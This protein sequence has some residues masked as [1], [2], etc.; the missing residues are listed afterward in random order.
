LHESGLKSLFLTPRSVAFIGVPR[1]SGP[2]WLNPV[3]NL[4]SWGYEGAIHLVHPH[5]REIAGLRTVERISQVKT[6]VDL[7]VVST[8]RETIPGIM[9][10]CA[11]KAIRAVVVTNQGFGEADQRG[12]ELERDMIRAARSGGIRILGPNTLGVSNAFD[13]F[14][15]SF[16]PLHREEV[17]VGLICQSGV[18]F[19]G[20]SH[21]VGGMGLAVDLGN[22]CDLDLSDALEWLGCDSRLKVIALH[23]ETVSGGRRFLEVASE[24]SKR[25]PLVALKTGR[26]PEG[27][28]AAAS[29]TGAMAA[30]DRLVDA[31]L[32]KAG[33]LRVGES[34][35]MIDL[36][37]GFLRLPPMRGPRVAVVTLTGA[38]AII[39][40]D[41]MQG[42]GLQPAPLDR[43]TLD[44]IQKL[45]P[46]WMNLTNPTDLWPAVMKH[47]MKT[48][49]AT[50]LRDALKD[51][52]VDG[53][54]CLALALEPAEQARLGAIDVIRELSEDSS[55]PVA[56]WL[57]GPQRN[58]ARDELEQQ[59]RTLAVPSLERGIRLLGRIAQYEQWRQNSSQGL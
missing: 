19:V 54:L 35:E 44:S 9:E 46:P 39:V 33:I 47:G 18:F 42:A 13:R 14:N 53:V 34:D 1:K 29:H 26:S 37:R 52:A 58:G 23:A 6:P 8:P 59:G 17:P 45:S 4:K 27:A 36:V 2:G 16:M 28:R 24:V 56:V 32:R 21:M 10:E 22:A 20:V 11:Q 15:S 50:A 31:V 49:Y 48:A 40:L 57:Y 30:E 43:S 12:A 55:K 3:D 41:A 5:A 38:G 7:A 51:P 25:I